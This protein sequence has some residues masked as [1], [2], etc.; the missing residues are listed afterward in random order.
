LA[1][2]GQVTHAQDRLSDEVQRVKTIDFTVADVDREASF[3]TKILQFE[4]IADFRLVGGE[5]GKLLGVFNA[6]MRIVHLRLGDQIVEL[7]QYV[8]PPAGR[9]IPA[10]SY[11]NDRWFQHMA[12][13]VRD[14]MPLTTSCKTTTCSRFPLIQSRS[15]HPILARQVSRRSNSTTRNVTIW[16]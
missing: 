3:F 8:S 15:H 2:C 11:S 6:S 1:T 9:P 12:I 16:N 13:V 4:K 14:M 5:W 7:T 10:P